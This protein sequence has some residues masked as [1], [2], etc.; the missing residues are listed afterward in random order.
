MYEETVGNEWGEG[1][2]KCMY[3]VVLKLQSINCCGF[4]LSMKIPTF[5]VETRYQ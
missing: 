5:L 3:V 4:K 2:D 1:D